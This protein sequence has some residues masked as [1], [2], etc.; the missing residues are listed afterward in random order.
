MNTLSALAGVPKKT[1][2]RCVLCADKAMQAKDQQHV[3]Q[4]AL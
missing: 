2:R 1:T 4:E 3:V